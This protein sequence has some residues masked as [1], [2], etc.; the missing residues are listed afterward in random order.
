MSSSGLRRR[1]CRSW[2]GSTRPFH[3]HRVQGRRV[4]RGLLHP[5]G[6]RRSAGHQAVQ[7]GRRAAG[8]PGAA[9]WDRLFVV[10]AGAAV[11][12]VAAT[13]HVPRNGRQRLDE[14]HVL[15]SRRGA[16]LGRRLL[17]QVRAEAVAN[18]ARQIWLETQAGNLPAIRAYRRLG[19]RITGFDVSRYRRRTTR[20]WPCSCP[21]PSRC[22][23]RSA[24]ADRP[25]RPDRPARTGRS[26][27]RPPRRRSR[28]RC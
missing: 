3:R 15:P 23:T 18:G 7:P 21:V 10:R 25:G 2:S 26:G 9:H 28:C 14:L 20:R 8:R 4:R 11:V 13:T 19:F 6:G 12:A 27:R 1:T 16:G 5:G 24:T 17:D 22:P